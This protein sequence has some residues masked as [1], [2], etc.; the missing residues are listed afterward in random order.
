MVLSWIQNILNRFSSI[1]NFYLYSPLENSFPKS[2]NIMT[3]YFFNIVL[4][5]FS[6][7]LVISKSGVSLFFTILLLSTFFSK[8]I[9][10]KQYAKF[11]WLILFFIS[12]LIFQSLISNEPLLSLLE[13]IK[14]WPY[15]LIYI[16][17]I[18]FY[19]HRQSFAIEIVT[20]LP[21]N[22]F[23]VLAFSAVT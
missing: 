7:S 15:L 1:S 4:F 2:V 23:P 13:L 19:H 14:S 12:T 22:V 16:P 17:I 5:L 20:V 9:W 21:F 6:L 10:Q 18:Y 3:A 8:T 11:H